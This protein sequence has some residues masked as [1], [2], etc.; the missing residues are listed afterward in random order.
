M[1]I[2]CGKDQEQLLM[3]L[4]GSGG[5]GKTVTINA[6]HAIFKARNVECLLSK[7]ATTGI[8][9]SNIGGSTLHWW[10][11]IPVTIPNGNFYRASSDAIKQRCCANIK[12]KWFLI[13]DEVS[14][15]TLQALGA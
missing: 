15:L 11:G 8:A 5:T 2:L 3:L 6:M 1:A 14:M 4:I 9:A 10:A 7:T 13:V 12:D